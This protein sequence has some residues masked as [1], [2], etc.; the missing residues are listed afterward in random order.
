MIEWKDISF[1]ES[2]QINDQ[3]Y[4]IY[5]KVSIFSFSY[6]FSSLLIIMYQNPTLNTKNTPVSSFKF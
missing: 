6:S 1:I 3:S 5:Q 2:R 4:L